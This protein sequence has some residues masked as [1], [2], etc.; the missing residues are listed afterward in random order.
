MIAKDARPTPETVAHAIVRG[1]PVRVL[2]INAGKQTATV[3]SKGGERSVPLSEIRGLSTVSFYG[4][5]G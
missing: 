4:S 1:E 2:S 3:F 5:G